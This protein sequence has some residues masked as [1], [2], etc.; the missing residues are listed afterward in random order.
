VSV[1]TCHHGVATLEFLMPTCHGMTVPIKCSQR[2]W[3]LLTKG[4]N[5]ALSAKE[6]L[7]VSLR[8]LQDLQ[9][10]NIDPSFTFSAC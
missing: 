9:S 10:L 7:I 2:D 8:M 5:Q 6:R 1:T 4:G 3:E